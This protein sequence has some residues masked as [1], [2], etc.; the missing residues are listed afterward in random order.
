MSTAELTAH[1]IYDSYRFSQLPDEVK[2]SLAVLFITS[3]S[4][5]KE[6]DTP[7]ALANVLTTEEKK[8]RLMQAV[9]DAKEGRTYS[10]EEIHRKLDSKYPWLA[11][12]LIESKKKSKKEAQ[13][14]HV[15]ESL[16]RAL[17]EVKEMK[18][19]NYE[20]VQTMDEFLA[21]LD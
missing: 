21:E 9:T 11:D 18:K 16:Q 2:R 12:K 1:R 10:S 7:S 17:D 3:S 8:A 6:D 13:A 20:G 19:K 14:Q 4:V 5:E 15:R